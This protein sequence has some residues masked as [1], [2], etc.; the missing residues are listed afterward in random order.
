MTLARYN[1]SKKMINQQY[2][3]SQKMKVQF[4]NLYENRKLNL[5]EQKLLEEKKKN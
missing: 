1:E 5:F 3:E 2:R 4:L